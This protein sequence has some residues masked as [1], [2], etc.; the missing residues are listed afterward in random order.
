[1]ITDVH[2]GR[3][4]RVVNQRSVIVRFNERHDTIPVVTTL[5]ET[6]DGTATSFIQGISRT[7]VTVE[8]STSFSGYLHL[9]AFSA[10]TVRT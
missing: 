6:D 5:L 10:F 7:E 8:F 3:R 9:Q 1:M 4:I 2:E